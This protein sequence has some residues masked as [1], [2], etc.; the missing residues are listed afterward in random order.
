MS[1]NRQHPKRGFVNVKAMPKGPSGNPLCRRCGT[2]T[3]G[4]N[5]TFCGEA[6]VHVWK[7]A[8]QPGYA[9]QHVELRDAGICCLCHPDA[10]ELRRT[11][12]QSADSRWQAEYGDQPVDRRTRE[13][14]R[15]RAEERSRT[16]PHCL[17]WQMDHRIPVIEGGG[18][19]AD[20]STVTA[21]DLLANLRTLCRPH[22]AE[23]TKA[24]AGRRAEQRRAAKPNAQLTLAVPP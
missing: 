5:R 9:R 10:D 14:H 23:E 19:P 4:K 2:E 12:A 11:L 3:P 7:I 24:L 16:G 13:W 1:Q 18:V 17:P 6:C 21:A 20:L 15:F 8:T 22:H